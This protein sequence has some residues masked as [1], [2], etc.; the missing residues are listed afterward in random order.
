MPGAPGTPNGGEKR[1]GAG[2]TPLLGPWTVWRWAE[3]AEVGVGVEL[4]LVSMAES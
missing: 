1:N 2:G 3:N 4:S